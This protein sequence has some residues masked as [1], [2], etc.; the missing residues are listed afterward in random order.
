MGKEKNFPDLKWQP[1]AVDDCADMDAYFAVLII[2]KVWLLPD[3]HVGIDPMWAA[4]FL[5]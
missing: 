1:P 4:I 5:Y 2:T 3:A